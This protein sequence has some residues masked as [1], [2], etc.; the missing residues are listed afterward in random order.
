MKT[1]ITI[2]TLG[3]GFKDMLLI[4]QL[5]QEFYKEG[6]KIGGKRGSP[7]VKQFKPYYNAIEED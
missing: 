7:Q 2:Y 4:P 3:A 6:D 5:E 1:Q